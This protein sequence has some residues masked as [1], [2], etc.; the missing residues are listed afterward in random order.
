MNPPDPF[1]LREPLES[2]PPQSVTEEPI[3]VV[4]PQPWPSWG[5]L[6][7][8]ALVILFLLILIIAAPV[9]IGFAHLLPAFSH[10][11]V[12]DLQANVIVQVVV[13]AVTYLLWLV[14]VWVFVTHKSREPLFHAIKWRWPGVREFWVLTLV[15]FLLVVIDNVG[16]RFVPVP[17]H[18]P[19]EDLFQT[20][21]SA[22]AVSLFGVLFA[23]F[24]E[25][26]FFRGLL[27]PA[28]RERTGLAPAILLTTIGFT[29]MH[30]PEWNF[31]WGPL[32]ILGV[33]GLVVTLV[34]ER[35]GSLAASWIVHAVYNALLLGITLIE[36]H[37]FT[38]ME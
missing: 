9:I 13:Q 1:N 4:I 11:S 30:G 38:R 25:E 21:T 33:V 26:L 28:L 37:G 3:R 31:A 29:A 34:R 20:K 16:G 7:L 22:Y 36:T 2:A 23:P 5:L 35:T 24:F 14:L 19:F 27:Y 12:R 8:F 18:T 15:G 6:D 32:L 10:Q 17:D